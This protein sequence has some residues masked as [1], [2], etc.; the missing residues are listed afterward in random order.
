M[1]LGPLL[2]FADTFEVD[3]VRFWDDL[4]AQNVTVMTVTA[5]PDLAKASLADSM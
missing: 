5:Q 2:V 3:R 1:V 4:H